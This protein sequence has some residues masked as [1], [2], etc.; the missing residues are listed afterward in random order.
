M[1]AAAQRGNAQ[2]QARVFDAH[3]N[4]VAAQV[5]RMT[6]DPSCVDDLVQEVFISAFAALPGFRGDSQLS[7]WLY[8]IAT[9]KVR[10]W[11][12]AQ[13]RRNVREKAAAIRTQPEPTPLPDEQAAKVEHRE[14]LYQALGQLPDALREAF[15]ARAIEGMSL[16][17]TSAKLGVPVSTVSYRARRAEQLLLEALGLEG[18]GQ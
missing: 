9:N 16:A 4:Q 18:S 14:R 11:W 15:V 7:T 17:D 8:R 13:R 10:N 3:K 6:G 1:L 2:A 5:L 12:D